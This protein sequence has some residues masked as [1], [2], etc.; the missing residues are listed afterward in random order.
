[1]DEFVRIVEKAVQ[2]VKNHP[3]FKEVVSDINESQ[4]GLHDEL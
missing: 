2:H 4:G 1:M 3:Q